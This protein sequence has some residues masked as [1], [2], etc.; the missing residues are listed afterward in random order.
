MS[1]TEVLAKGMRD[2]PPL[3]KYEP[4]AAEMPSQPLL[5]EGCYFISYGRDI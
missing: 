2:C 1:G 5:A 4:R 3:P